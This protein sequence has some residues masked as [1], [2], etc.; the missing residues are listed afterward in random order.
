MGPRRNQAAP[1]NHRHLKGDSTSGYISE[2]LF[3]P[4]VDIFTGTI[5]VNTALKQL[6]QVLVKYGLADDSNISGTSS[7][8]TDHGSL[9]GLGDNDHTQYVLDSGDT[10]TGFLTLNADPTNPLHAVTKQ[11]VD[12]ALSIPTTDL[13]VGGAFD[14]TGTGWSTFWYTGTVTTTFDNTG[15]IGAGYA[16]KTVV[17]ANPSSQAY[18]QNTSYVPDA[19]AIGIQGTIDCAATVGPMQFRV[20]ILWTTNGTTPVYLGTGTT[21]TYVSTIDVDAG[22]T[23]LNQP[24][25]WAFPA[26]LTNFRIAVRAVTPFEGYVVNAVGWLDNVKAYYIIPGTPTA[27]PVYGGTIYRNADLNMTG[28]GLD[29]PLKRSLVDHGGFID[30]TNGK[31]VVPS[32]LGGTYDINATVTISGGTASTYRQIQIQKNGNALAVARY[33]P[34]SAG[35]FQY[36]KLITTDL[37]AGDIIHLAVNNAGA[38]TPSVIGNNNRVLGTT[39]SIWRR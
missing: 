15:P 8:A 1:G 5:P 30:T 26:G 23:L 33:V 16:G 25:S 28:A 11:Y 20:E 14:S 37:V 13:V 32:G 19:S 17:G 34:E 24:F 29:V 2:T 38:G 12:N 9:F 3:D 6:L 36:N 4:A 31:L 22:Q 7:G 27:V 35:E 10:M 18:L 21:A 39:L